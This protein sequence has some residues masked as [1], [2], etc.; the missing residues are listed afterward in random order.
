LKVFGATKQHGVGKW[1][2]QPGFEIWDKTLLYIFSIHKKK[3]QQC[4]GDWKVILERKSS[5]IALFPICEGGLV[6]LRHEAMSGGRLVQ[7]ADENR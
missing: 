6:A 2:C 4:L 3:N 5:D 1:L 7:C